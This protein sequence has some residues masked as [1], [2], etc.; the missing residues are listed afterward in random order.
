MEKT[1]ERE[2]KQIKSLLN[3][4]KKLPN[5]NYLVNINSGI[6]IFIALFLL[7]FFS[8]DISLTG[9]FMLS[10]ITFCCGGF[11]AIPFISILFCE[12]SKRDISKIGFN[13]DYE[14]FNKFYSKKYFNKLKNKVSLKSNSVKNVLK[15]LNKNKIYSDNQILT[16]LTKEK[17]KE[18]KIEVLIKNEE[19][20]INKILSKSNKINSKE[21]VYFFY[22]NYIDKLCKESFNKRKNDLTNFILKIDLDTETKKNIMLKIK[23][24]LEKDLKLDND[25]DILLNSYKNIQNLSK[26]DFSIKKEKSCVVRE[27]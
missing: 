16:E 2:V 11:F 18:E 17:I 19:K 23:T 4:Y 21:I 20:I 14:D 13:E 15:K 6:I 7:S 22:T 8:Q 1:L 27:I 5:H 25:E 26:Q 10:L 12:Y 24:R 3:R 9:S